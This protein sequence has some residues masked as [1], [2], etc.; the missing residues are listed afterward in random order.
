MWVPDYI[1]IAGNELADA[2]AGEGSA[3]AFIVPELE[4]GI[5]RVTAYGFLS[6]WIKRKH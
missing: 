3:N 4:S 2:L 5:T 1:E 6:N